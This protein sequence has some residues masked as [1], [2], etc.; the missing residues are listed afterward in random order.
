[1]HSNPEQVFPSPGYSFCFQITRDRKL[2]FNW[3]HHGEYELTVCRNGKGEAHIGE[4]IRP[5]RGPA[6]FFVAPNV[7]HALVSHKTFDGWIIQIPRLILERYEGRS[8]FTFL[9]A[10]LRR[11]E[12][13]L[14]FSEEASARM[15]SFME[16]AE[17]ESG[18]FRWI[19][20]LETLYTASE[21][22]GAY[23]FTPSL[24]LEAK[25]ADKLDEIIRTLF[26]LSENSPCLKE[27]ARYA[28]MSVQ[29]FCRNFRKKTGM[30]FV[31]YLHSVRINN[32]KKLLQQ[33]K[34]YV[35]DISYEC[36]FNTVSFFNR[37][38]KESTGMTP[39]QYRKYF[40]VSLSS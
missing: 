12:A 28:G 15:V 37:K 20:L 14:E 5:F 8:E 30:S 38:F 18:V 26:N 40:G 24:A 17:G 21:D 4:A 2:H 27:A 9:T 32:A 31:E 6:A 22:G 11:T 25:A 23:T 3:H 10:L 13:A 19:R 7:P 39:R 34:L 33:S 16:K 36:G 1:M 35:D 29:S